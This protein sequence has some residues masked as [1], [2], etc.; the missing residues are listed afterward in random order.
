MT[1]RITVNYS[2]EHGPC[3]GGVEV[4]TTPIETGWDRWRCCFREQAPGVWGI[5]VETLRSVDGDG[6]R[7][8]TR[9][10]ASRW[11]C[12]AKVD[13]RSGYVGWLCEHVDLVEV[14]GRAFWRNPSAA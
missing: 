14:D 5:A 11:L 6:G 7:P 8:Q 4:L 13:G 3:P 9:W 2:P 1:L 12:R 10:E